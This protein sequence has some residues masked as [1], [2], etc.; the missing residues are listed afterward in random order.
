MEGE[1]G[2]DLYAIADLAGHDLPDGNVIARNRWTGAQMPLPGEVFNAITYCDAFRTLEGQVA[3]LAGPNARG[4]EGEIR[5]IL[6]AV[7]N[8]G[9]MLSAQALA[10]RLEPKPPSHGDRQAEVAVLTC[11]RPQALARLLGS[12]LAHAN[13]ERIA[14]LTVVDDSRDDA[15]LAANRSSIEAVSATL[16]ARGFGP[17]R[18]FTPTDAAALVE[19][20]VQRMPDQETAIRFL[21]DRRNRGGYV[22]T[23]I[24]RNLAQLLAV[25]QPQLVFDDDVL[26]Q[27]FDSPER[28][29]GIEFS[30]RQRG[31]RFYRQ[32]ADWQALQAGERTCP[33][34]RHLEV[35]GRSLPE[36]LGALPGA[37]PSA[38]AFEF[39]QPA[40]AQRLGAD[41]RVLVSQCGS[42]GDP[43]SA[44][45][46]WV[47]LLKPEVRSALFEMA[48]D[49]S[50]STVGRNCWLGRSRPVFEPRA[51]MSQLT[52][53]DNNQYLPPY[54]PLH[55]GQDK[56]FGAMVEFIYP[57]NVVAD[58]P[59]AIPHLPMPERAWSEG[60]SRFKLSFSL[61]H[62]LHDHVTGL[63]SSCVASSPGM[64]NQWLSN[65]FLDLADAPR[66]R[67]VEGAADHWTQQRIEWLKHLSQALE[68]TASGSEAQTRFLQAS[69]R[70]L[71][72]CN[73]R[74][75]HREP[76]AGPQG[77]PSG[78]AALDY[79]RDGWRN[80]GEGLAAWP[81]IREAVAALN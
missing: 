7:I 25:G 2:A 42:L 75:F 12:L 73:I 11:D 59:F 76:F 28:E 45:A 71:Q 66:E 46:E 49:L 55:R 9:L 81:A 52:G 3:H 53:L 44:G 74:D 19:Q 14:G 5:Q 15:S 64:R 80:F 48:G 26:C 70:D 30:S 4:R 78:E 77:G 62:F 68:Q 31:C 41:S 79:W 13:F 39:A 69:I 24:S 58:L 6:Q 8:G 34:S 29:P 32:A 38:A 43:G 67:I 33:V 56:I 20:L 47:A 22:T 17:I 37:A 60:Q 63:L 51:V 23:G 36:S 72:A 21:L 65:Q 57:A 35:L 10:A 1:T 54:F 40:F 50:Q 61:G 18:H 27:V 16:K